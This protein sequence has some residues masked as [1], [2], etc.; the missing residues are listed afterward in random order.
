MKLRAWF[1]VRALARHGQRVYHRLKHAPFPVVGA[2]SGMA[3]GGGCEVLLHCTAVQAHAETYM[4]LVEAGV[5]IVP[6]WGGCKEL[7]LRRQACRR[8]PF[9]PMPAV[10]DVFKTIAMATVAKSAAE[11]KNLL[12]LRPGDGITRNLDRLLADAKAKALELAASH[13]AAPEQEIRLPGR[14]AE[15]ALALALEGFRRTGKATSHDVVV[16]KALAR[17]LSG[18]DTDMTEL[19]E[20]GRPAFARAPGVACPRASSCQRGAGRAHAQDRQAAEELNM[21][22]TLAIVVLAIIMLFGVPAL[23]ARMISGPLL[24]RLG[25]S[26]PRIG[27]T[28]RIALEAGTVWWDGELFSGRPDWRKLFDFKPR[29]LSDAERAFLDGPVERLCRMIDDW[30]ITQDRRISRPR[31]GT[32][33]KRERF[34]GMIIPEKY[35][36]LGFSA[37]GHSAVIVKIASRSI[38]TACTVMVPNSLGP[39]ELLLHYGTEGQREHYLPRLAARRGD[40]LLRP[41]RTPCRQRCRSGRS[42]GIVCRGN[43]EGR[44]VLGIRLD[45]DKRYITLAPVATLIGLAFSLHDPDRL[46]GGAR[47]SRHHVRADAR[48]HTRHPHRRAP[49]SA[50]SPVPQRPDLRPGRVRADRLRHRREGRP[51]PGLAHADG[52]PGGRPLHLPASAVGR[53]CEVSLRMAGAYA[54]VR[55]QFGMPIGRFEGIEEPLARIAG[56]AYLMNAVRVLTCGAVDAGEKPAVL[57]AIAKTYLTE[58]MRD[59]VNDAMDVLAGRGICRGPRN[60]L[61]RVYAA[62]PIGITVEGANILTRSLIIFGQGAIRCHPFLREEMAAIEKRDVARFDRALF[63]HLRFFAGNALRALC[64]GPSASAGREISRTTPISGRHLRRLARMSAAF[65]LISDL[66]LATLG[67]AFKRREKLSGRL[68]DAVAWMYVASAAVKCFHDDGRRAADVPL[69]TWTCETALWKVQESLVAV[70]DNLPARWAGRLLSLL[71]FPFG[72]RRKPPA[73]CVGRS[74]GALH[75]GRRRCLGPAD[76]RYFCSGRGRAGARI[77]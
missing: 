10:T 38:S 7:L 41:D 40:S 42:S 76:R 6:A 53:S 62:V 15:A 25:P 27:D 26:M 19:R 39:A 64:S 75:V 22:P 77:S 21:F 69:L 35:G 36:G 46:L 68:A 52:V 30:Q 20:R 5:G 12:F 44:E 13:T 14:T 8:P 3:L 18:G 37:L 55:E 11:A 17:V 9:G 56:N 24:R 29:P 47:G 50:G 32:I 4:G 71:I 48:E 72:A 2:P 34:F 33:L 51:R 49:R 63:G 73:R 74:R 45:F 54:S 61:A 66:T 16:G 60:P 43:F 70:C 57:S 59:S 65:A 31:S 67:G 58:A 1:L 23:R 28:E